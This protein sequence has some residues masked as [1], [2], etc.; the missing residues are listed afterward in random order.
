MP[1]FMGK[2]MQAFFGGEPSVELDVRVDV[3]EVRRTGVQTAVMDGHELK[4]HGYAACER[5]PHQQL[6]PVLRHQLANLALDAD[7]LRVCHVQAHERP[8]I[9]FSCA[10]AWPGRAFPPTACTSCAQTASLR[11]PPPDVRPSPPSH[12]SWPWRRSRW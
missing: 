8:L 5:K 1:Y 4:A 2:H 9:R 3:L 6:L 10:G 11:N 12:P 7:D